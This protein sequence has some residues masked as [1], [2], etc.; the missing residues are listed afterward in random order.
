MKTIFY[1]SSYFK[2]IH[3]LTNVLKMLLHYNENLFKFT[4]KIAISQKPD[5][6]FTV[7]TLK[8]LVRFI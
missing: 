8:L 3:Q 5:G 4:F 2:D 7:L 6:G 1:A